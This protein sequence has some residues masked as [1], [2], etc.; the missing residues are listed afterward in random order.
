MEKWQIS[1]Q[2]Q[3][4]QEVSLDRRL[5]S[6]SKEVLKD[7]QTNVTGYK[8]HPERLPSSQIWDNLMPNE[9]IITPDCVTH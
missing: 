5:V 7:R 2:E 3:E 1:G 6:E 8:S 4:K 9:V